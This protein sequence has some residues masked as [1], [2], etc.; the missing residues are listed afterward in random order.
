MTN[1]NMK[2]DMSV[3]KLSVILVSTVLLLAGC[4]ED[5]FKDLQSD[6]RQFLAFRVSGQVGPP[7]IEPGEN[8]TGEVEVFVVDDDSDRTNLVPDFVISAGASVIPT[9]GEAVDLTIGARQKYVVTA[10]SGLTR[11]WIVKVSPF[12]SSI[13]GDWQLSN[14][15]LY[16]WYIGLGETWGWGVFGPF[17]ESTGGYDPEQYAPESLAKDLPDAALEDDNILTFKTTEI[18]ENGNPQ[19]TFTLDPGPD[20]E[21]APFV[22]DPDRFGGSKSYAVRFRNI[23]VEGGVWEFNETGKVLTLWR[24]NMEGKA[25]KANVTINPGGNIRMA[26]ETKNED[27]PYTWD[28]FG[29]ESHLQNAITMYYDLRLKLN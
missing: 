11:E 16:D 22:I 29:A 9:P 4:T 15:I 13:E 8:N 18:N 27:D 25:F 6:D 28:H 3:F 23:P 12:E 20:G 10:E 14:G 2:M 19:G 5:P 24:R 1:T 26:F 17:D 7:I 21:F